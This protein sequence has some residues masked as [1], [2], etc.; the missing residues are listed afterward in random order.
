MERVTSPPGPRGLAVMA[1]S[2]AMALL[3]AVARAHVASA[4]AAGRP[5]LFAAPEP[6]VAAL[7]GLSLLLY[8]AGY[9]RLRARRAHDAP[10][11]EG[12]HAR[13]RQLLAFLG[14]WVALCI[15]LASPLDTL[16]GLLFSAHMVQHEML[17][18]VAAP[19][20]VMGRPLAVWLWAFPHGWRR[21]IARAWRWAP[22]LRAWH[23]VTGALAAWLLHAAALWLWH[24]PRFFQAALADPTIHAWQHA[25]FLASALLFWW[26]IFGMRR[27]AAP[28]GYAM[29]SLF[30]TMVHTGALG[31][32]LTL[33]PGLWYPAYIEPAAAL[34]ID[35]LR[36]QQLG[37]LV[38]WVPGGLAYLIGG[39]YVAWR[40]LSRPA[41]SVAGAALLA[42]AGAL[43]AATLFGAPRAEA[44]PPAQA[45]GAASA[46]PTS[47][48]GVDA[49]LIARGKYVASAGDC[50]GCHTNPKGGAPYAGGRELWSP[51]G[52][53]ISTNITPDPR[54][55]IG[56]YTY[57]EFS[58]ALRKGVARGGKPLYPAMPYASFARMTEDDMRALYA[59]VMHDIPPVDRSPPPTTLPFPF[60]QRWML[61][62]WQAMF[63]PDEAYQTRPEKDPQWNRG[64]YLVQALGHCGACHT[65][66]GPAFQER[67][68]DETS[69]HFLTGGVNDHWFA[70]NLNSGMGSGLGRLGVDELAAFMKTGYSNGNMAYGSMVE[71]IETSLQHLSDDDL[72]AIAVYLK[73]LPPNADAGRYIPG[74]AEVKEATADQGNRTLDTESVGAAVYKSFCAQCHQADGRGIPNVYPRLAGNPSLLAKDKTSLMR[75]VMEGGHSAATQHGPASQHMPPF[76][77]ILTDAQIA[78]VLTFVRGSWG[79]D[80]PPVSGTEVGQMRQALKK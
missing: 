62:G 45:G 60:N 18:I 46:A 33:A 71:T 29:L 67:G 76:D 70:P 69:P 58:R 27:R 49:M 44:A 9:L 53:I 65:P 41:L 54:H 64:A 38:M 32:L 63:V 40:W 57:E 31:A 23:L 61:R 35:A 51:F 22:L 79:N 78:Q 48:T 6:W 10:S 20:L 68:D 7:L 37:G 15:A 39:L 50:M 1:L 5:V 17:M 75:I 72:R 43:M 55:G 19:M 21:P 73:S 30:T 8:L 42:A 52:T 26:P 28:D 25:S 80:A 59:Y 66:R 3:P 77:T 24:V 56:G 16:S 14:G 47:G 34:G 11:H 2:S 36:D 74:R 12:D 4:G 13:N